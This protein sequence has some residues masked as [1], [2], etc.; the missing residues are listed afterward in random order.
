MIASPGGVAEWPKALVLKTS[1]GRPS[2]SSNLSPS[3]ISMQS[4]PP[5]VS[6]D[7][8]RRIM[9]FSL[10]VH[11]DPASSQ[12]VHSALQF[13]KATVASGHEL[14]RVFFYH[15]G[16][17]IADCNQVPPQDESNLLQQWVEFAEEHSLELTVCIA[18]A[19]KRGVLNED[20]RARYER[21]AANVHP[22][23]SVVG[24]GQQ[25][26]AAISCDRTITFPG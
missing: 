2:E 4:S 20:E 12:S 22:A 11:G 26:E 18:A 17:R 15:D 3:A 7:C 5:G 23:F 24:L 14:Y 10:N 6:Y 21:V 19:L 8:Y 25:I 1:E 16:V 13:A 9:M